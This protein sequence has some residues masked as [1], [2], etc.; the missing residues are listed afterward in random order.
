[1]PLTSVEERLF[2]GLAD[3]G[4]AGPARCPA[5]RRAGRHGPPS[6]R[7]ARGGAARLAT[8]PGRRPGR[9]TTAPGARH[10]RRRAAAPG[11]A[12][13]EPAARRD[14]GRHRPDRAVE[15][16]ADQDA[17]G[18]RRDRDLAPAVPRHLPAVAGRPGPG[19]RAAGRRSTPARSRVEITADGVGRYPPERGGG[20][21]LLLPGGSAERREA[22]RRHRRGSVPCRRIGEPR[23]SSSRTTAA[24]FDPPPLTPG[25]GL[26]NMRDR[27]ESV[28]RDSLGRVRA[29]AAGP[30][31]PLGCPGR[32]ADVRARVAWVLAGRHRRAGRRRTSR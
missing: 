14:A 9:G 2:E 1:M 5:P 18:A 13:R 22:R 20:G 3:P 19:R 16:L 10:P 27:L 23:R 31:S 7:G 4:A 32:A 17:G 21:V 29:R 30:R 8:A 12:G 24:G 11:R 26:A 15:L 25:T 28:E 6:C